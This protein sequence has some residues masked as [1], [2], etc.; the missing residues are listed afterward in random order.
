LAPQL[1]VST[2]D[3]ALMVKIPPLYLGS[4]YGS[5]CACLKFTLSFS[6]FL[7]SMQNIKWE[8][9]KWESGVADFTRIWQERTKKKYENEWLDAQ[10]IRPQCA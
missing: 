9:C 4:L 7:E 6:H 1:V 5:K 10:K 2:H 8:K 3:Q